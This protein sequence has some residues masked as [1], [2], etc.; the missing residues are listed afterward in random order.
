MWWDVDND[1]DFAQGAAILGQFV[2][3]WKLRTPAQ[4]AHFEEIANGHLRR[5]LARNKSFE[6]TNVEV[7]DSALLYK[8]VGRVCGSTW[9]GPSAVLKF[10]G[11]GVRV[12][13]RS[14]T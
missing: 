3:R 5:L 1:L 6:R 10:D 2:R 12:R 9:R 11:A 13:F 14:Q 4:G 8:L 7:G